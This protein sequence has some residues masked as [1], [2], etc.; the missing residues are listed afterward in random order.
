MNAPKLTAGL[1]A[2][3]CMTSLFA[4]ADD[5]EFPFDEADLYFE[6]NH[7]DGDLGIHALIDGDPWKKLTIEDPTDR[8][9]M[10]IKVKGKL[11][12]QGLTELFFESAEP[13]FDELAPE[14]FFAR[15]PEG[16]YEIEGITLEGEELESSA[17]LSHVMPAPAEDIYVSGVAAS[18]DC[19]D[20]VPEVSAPVTIEWA[21][22]VRSHPDV[23]EY[24]VIEVTKYQLVVEREE[25][26]LLVYSVDLPSDVTSF[27]VP[28]AFTDLGEE[29][30]Y[31]IL[32]REAS[33]NQTAVESCFAME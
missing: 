15:F 7:T 12:R 3:L 5:D 27:S 10:V 17:W 9:M 33:G 2:A 22:V 1:A 13:P 28:E 14:D 31:E 26:E 16:E 21:P 8:K 4:Q 11:K 18:D 30:K 19:D 20:D 32:V 25:P 24:G 29:F 23:G 6:M